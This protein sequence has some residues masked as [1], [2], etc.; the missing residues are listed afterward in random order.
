MVTKNISYVVLA[1]TAVVLSRAMFALF[2]DPEGPNLLVVG[3]AAVFVFGVSL[4]VNY[5]H[6]STFAVV[7][8]NRLIVAILA[9]VVA[10][11]VIYCFL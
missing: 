1:L 3:I 5:F 9:Q 4:A 2:D 8:R 7:G 10:V 6:S 11:A